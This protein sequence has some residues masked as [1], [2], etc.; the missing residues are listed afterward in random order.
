M[1][2][3]G[4][5]YQ[6]ICGATAVPKNPSAVERIGLRL[7]YDDTIEKADGKRHKFELQVN[8][9]SKIPSTLKHAQ[10]SGTHAVIARLRT[11]PAKPR[12]KRF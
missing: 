5:S 7:D 9:G 6:L 4:R 2:M 11:A 12:S 10:L 3:A 8:A 1:E